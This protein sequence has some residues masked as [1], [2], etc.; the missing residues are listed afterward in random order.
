[1]RVRPIAGFL[2]AGL[3]AGTALPAGAQ[4]ATEP[5]GPFGGFKHDS[6]APIEITSDALEVRQADNLAIFSGGVVA[7]QGT[8]KLTA[9]R[10]E[11]R[12]DQNAQGNSETGA[13]EN[14]QAEGDVFLTNGAETAQGQ[15]AEYDVD[16]GIITMTGSVVLTQGENV[17]SGQRLVIDLN[18]GTGKV[19]GRVR[20]VFTPQQAEKNQ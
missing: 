15:H 11:V 5:G 19:E 20:S 9:E 4:G 3:L 6:T 10:V 14:M 2:L 12:Y 7:G 17:I 1:M 18:A 8:L 13:I 16:S